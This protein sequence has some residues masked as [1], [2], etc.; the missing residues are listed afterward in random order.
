MESRGRAHI[1]L[2]H[3]DYIIASAHRRRFSAQEIEPS[4]IQIPESHPNRVSQKEQ[5]RKTAAT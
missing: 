2:Q 5:K 4:W 3:S 1:P